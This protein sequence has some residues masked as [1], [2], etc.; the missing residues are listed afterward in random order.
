MKKRTIP[1]VIEM[2]GSLFYSLT[3]RKE[4]AVELEAIKEELKSATYHV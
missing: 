2:S 3:E 4:M 1:T